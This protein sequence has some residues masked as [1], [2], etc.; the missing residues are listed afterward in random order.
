MWVIDN[1]LYWKGKDKKIVDVIRVTISCINECNTLSESL[2]LIKNLKAILRENKHE[3]RKQPGPFNAYLSKALGLYKNKQLQHLSANGLAQQAEKIIALMRAMKVT[4]DAVSCINLLKIHDATKQF[5]A[6]ERLLLGNEDGRSYISKW[7][8][9][10]NIKV[11]GAFLGVCAET[12]QF[13][14]AQKV[15]TILKDN[16]RAMCPKDEIWPDAITCIDL[17]TVY[18]ATKHFKAAERLVLGNE[19]GRS[20]ISEWEVAINIKVYNAFLG[21]C[22]ETEQFKAAQQVLTILDD[23]TRARRPKNEIWPTT[24]TCINLLTVYSATKQFKAAERLVM[25]ERSYMSEWKVAVNINVYNAFLGVCAETQQFNAAQQVL[26]ILDDNARAMRPKDE[27]KPDAITCIELLT[28]YAATKQ[29]KAAE[30]LVLVNEHGRSYISKWKVAINIRVYNA[31]LGVCAKTEQFKAA[32]QVLTI[33]KDNLRAMWPK[34]QIKPNVITCTK[35]LTVYAAT[36]EFKA[37]ERLVMGERSYMSEWRVAVDIKVYGAFLGVCAQTE[38]FKAAQNILTILEDNLRA[39][40]PKD[41]IKPD[42]I[43]CIEL[44]TVYSATKQFKAAER[45]VM[46]ERSYMSE[47]KVAVDIKVYGAFLG[48]CAQTQQFEAAQKVLSILK[49]NAR[50]MWPKDEIWPNAITCIELLTVYAATKQFKAAE[51]LVFG[52]EHGRSYISEWKVAVNIKVYGAF[53]GVCA[54]TEQFEAA[55]K[56]LSILKGNL[57]AMWPKDEIKPNAITC[58]D[59]L[60]VYAATKQFKAA[61][62]L[63]LGNE[64]RRSYISKWKVAV[65]IKVYGAFLGVCAQTEQFEAA[66]KVLT[67]LNDNA[68]AMEPKNEIKPDAITCIVLLTVYAATKQFKAAERLV[69]DEQSYMSEWKVA[70]NIKVYNAFLGVCAQTEQFEA[71]QKVLS[72]LKDNVLAE[73]PKNAIKPDAITCIEL[74][75]VYTATN[76]F[77]AAERLVFGNKQE[78]SYLLEWGITPNFLIYAYWALVNENDFDK[79][80]DKLCR[81]DLCHKQLGLVGSVFNCHV[82]SIFSC[83]LSKDISSGVPFQFAK[84]L[85]QYH[86]RR[87]GKLAIEKIIT[88]HHLGQTLKTNFISFLKEEHQ[89]EFKPCA[90]NDGII[91]LKAQ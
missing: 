87:N 71:A 34:E 4:P 57:K 91:K 74:L 66:Q 63:V 62:R 11:Y 23:N 39:K 70:V 56:V 58:I 60:T 25:G 14:A 40:Q 10:V 77:E 35:L 3:L 59:L 68:R 12:Q 20:Y 16:A 37:A 7:K 13:K 79:S 36:K 47:W 81:L 30:C 8:I 82:D 42:A 90:S 22:A 46:G 31:F 67:I 17:L 15:L 2:A 86:C 19:H 52:N 65:N 43:T 32:Q 55:Q 61:E 48:V 50:A 73:Q 69:M 6:A 27:I 29:F 9:A 18:D 76:Q 45:L 33:L 78:Q 83:S 80:M 72:I 41:Q 49:D 1:F 64:H 5:E 44:L 53:L 54:Q 85:Y 24:I 75:T 51:R 89:L 26:T 38:Q 28:V 88:G 84:A 21:V